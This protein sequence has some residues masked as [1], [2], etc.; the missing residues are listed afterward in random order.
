[1]FGRRKSTRENK[2]WKFCKARR[3]KASCWG[4][5]GKKT[6]MLPWGDGVLRGDGLIS[7]DVVGVLGR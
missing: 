5:G 7:V 2:A 1:M 6:E 3:E 4:F